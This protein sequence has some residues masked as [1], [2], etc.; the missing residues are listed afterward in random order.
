MTPSSFSF[1]YTAQSINRSILSFT[2]LGQ[3]LPYRKV[4]QMVDAGSYS[5][6]SSCK[7]TTTSCD[8][9]FSGVCFFDLTSLVIQ[10][11][12]QINTAVDSPCTSR[13]SPSQVEVGSRERSRRR[14][15][16]NNNN[17]ADRIDPFPVQ[18]QQHYADATMNNMMLAQLMKDM[19]VRAC[20]ADDT[21]WVL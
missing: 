15:I 13:V 20:V 21:T 8:S 6:V 5:F 18:Q 12:S 9:L 4:S 16:N 19:Q 7:T 14:P 11:G 10:I 1:R 2:D 3:F 17:P